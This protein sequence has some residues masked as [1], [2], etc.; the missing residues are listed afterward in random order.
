ML[1]KQCFKNGWSIDE[2]CKRY[3]RHECFGNEFVVND[4]CINGTG[5]GVMTY[6]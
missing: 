4:I 2:Q 5:V 3:G 1:N 6:Q